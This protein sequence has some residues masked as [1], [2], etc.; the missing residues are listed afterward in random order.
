VIVANPTMMAAYRDGLPADGKLFPD[1]SKVAKIEWT[2]KRNTVS[3]YFVNVPD[4]LKKLKSGEQLDES[5]RVIHDA[6][7]VGVIHELHN[8]IDTVV[9]DAYGWHADLFDEDILARLV[10]LNK[11]RTEE[12]RRGTI[13][14][15]RP[16]YQATNFASRPAARE[17]QIEADLETLDA[18]APSLPKDDADLVATLRATLR[19]IGK[20]IEP[21]A[22][23]AKFRD[24]GGKGT[25]RVERGLRLLAAA[26]VVRRSEAGWFL[27][28]D[29]GASGGGALSDE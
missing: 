27:P 1:G 17:E 28:A 14:W 16:E 22:I 2:F 19:L 18:H 13:R 20:P 4:T 7:C 23:A 15:I 8:K 11:E 29:R 25:R 3:P 5:E 6:G 9:A 10:S 24:G 21:K 26:G 12:E